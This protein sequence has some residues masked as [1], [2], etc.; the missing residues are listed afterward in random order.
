MNA[1]Y[2]NYMERIH[3]IDTSESILDSGS[4]SISVGGG[5]IGSL[6]VGIII[7][8]LLFKFL[9]KNCINMIS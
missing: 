8:Y 3:T 6:I 5:F 9:I 7:G 1:T 2:D 4:S